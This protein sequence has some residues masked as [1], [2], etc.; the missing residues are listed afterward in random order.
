[1]KKVIT[2]VLVL[3]LT[4]SAAACGG[5]TDPVSGV[6]TSAASTENNM[7]E[8]TQQKTEAAETS[9][10]A[11]ATEEES[12]ETVPET[13]ETVVYTL[14][15]IPKPVLT[16]YT[17]EEFDGEAYIYL[18]R[19]GCYGDVMDYEQVLKD[20]GFTLEV[21]KEY[22]VEGYLSQA[23]RGNAEIL[24]EFVTPPDI[25]EVKGE[26][27]DWGGVIVSIIIEEAE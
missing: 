2:M 6:E 15:T 9:A 16:G 3:V 17:Y 5:N 11:E 19:S 1:M 26:R 13:E 21:L 14:D 12:E 4:V 20:A 22:T 27:E 24:I 25:T 23:V 7:A 10:A 18:T 8:E